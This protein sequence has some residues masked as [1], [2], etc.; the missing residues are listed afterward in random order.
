M[1]RAQLKTPKPLSSHSR[2]QDQNSP[3]VARGAW[4][5]LLGL[6]PTDQAQ[7][8]K[9]LG[10]WAGTLGEHGFGDVWGLAVGGSEVRKVGASD[11]WFRVLQALGT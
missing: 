11:L 1:R 5:Q 3:L 4:R 9:N 6:D 2:L 10:L 7:V 8:R